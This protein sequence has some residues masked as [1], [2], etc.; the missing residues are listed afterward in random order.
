MLPDDLSMRIIEVKRVVNQT[1]GGKVQSFSALV[2]VGNGMRNRH[3]CPH[4]M[5]PQ[6]YLVLCCMLAGNGA[7]GYAK[8]KSYDPSKA[9]LIA[10][11]RAAR[12]MQF[13]PR[14]VSLFVGYP[15]VR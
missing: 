14:S 2:A 8:G 1:G 12:R 7:C 13:I 6:P 11:R 15:C 10:I 4:Y 3:V 9:T 5:H